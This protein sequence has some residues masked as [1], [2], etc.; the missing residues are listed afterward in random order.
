MADVGVYSHVVKSS[1]FPEFYKGGEVQPKIMM[2]F[3]GIT[4]KDVCEMTG[5]HSATLR[6]DDRMQDSVR[7]AF[8]ELANMIEF[9]A[10]VFEGD[11]N[12]ARIWFIITNL[13]LGDLSPVDMIKL[14][15]ANKLAQF[16]YS[17]K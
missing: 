6:F 17:A 1:H 14:G 16:I 12:K 9:V 8:I 4:R 3:L 2:K 7:T 10:N 15:K 11:R 13:N 5:T